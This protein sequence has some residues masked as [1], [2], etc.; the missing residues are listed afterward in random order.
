M[1]TYH[2]ILM[3]IGSGDNSLVT[4]LANEVNLKFDSD[5][6]GGVATFMLPY[7]VSTVGGETFDTTKLRKEDTV[8]I[9]FKEYDSFPQA[10][11][12]QF[13]DLDLIFDGYI[14]NIQLSKNKT[15]IPYQITAFGTLL[16]I[17]ERSLIYQVHSDILVDQRA[18]G[19]LT[20]VIPWVLQNTGLQQGPLGAADVQ[21][22]T[23]IIPQ[24][25]MRLIDT[26]LNQFVVSVEG[27]TQGKEVFKKIKEKYAVTIHQ[28]GDGFVNIITPSF[29][30]SSSSGLLE[31][32][33]WQFE[34]GVNAFD[35]D[36]GDLTNKI[37]SYVVIGFPPNV[38]MAIDVIAL[39]LKTRGRDVKP[40]D[41]N[42]LVEKNYNLRSQIDCNRVAREKLLEKERSNIT[43]FRTKFDPR[44]MIFQPLQIKDNDRYTGE[45]IF[46]IK[47][48]EV[49][50]TKGDV[51]CVINAFNHSLDVLPEE[52]V[53][54]DTGIADI[55]V[56]EIRT[57][58][59]D[60]DSWSNFDGI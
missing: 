46:F 44:F 42:Y 6:Y 54:S 34:V 26:S 60:T 1:T 52:I 18:D 36:Y 33:T 21:V 5:A 45:E 28:S 48:Y 24:S 37:N 38:G 55:D 32:D 29:L 31:V 56:L 7:T 2:K 16:L 10:Q 39:N 23:D 51:S 19:Q 59:E 11:V 15:A 58:I 25:K 8:Q 17:N 49:T 53:L 20:G 13:D 41:Y 57:K 47:S 9:G 4:D 27:G 50:L 22:D 12:A 35:I 30:L 14:D 43:S 40:Q 3:R